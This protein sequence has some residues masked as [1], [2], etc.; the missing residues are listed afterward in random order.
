MKKTKILVVTH[1]D[2]DD[3]YISKCR[4]YQ[5]IKVGN[6]IDNEF[7]L[8]KGWLIDN[9]GDNISNE[10][11][12]Y[13]ELTAQYGAWK[14][15][16][17]DVKYIGIV[18]YRRYFFEYHKKSENYFRDIISEKEIQN[19]LDKYKIIVPFYNVKY[20]KCSYLYKNKPE[21]EQD[22]NWV[23]IKRIIDSSY[24]E[25]SKIFEQAMEGK[26]SVR[27][28]MFITTRDIYDEYSKWLFD[29]LLKYDNILKQENKE[30]TARVDGFLSEHLLYVWIKYKF[31][32]KE[33]LQLESRNTEQDKF[34]DYNNGV[35]GK[36]TKIM[37]CNR[38]M[39]EFLKKLRLSLLMCLRGR[40]N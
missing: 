27:G 26:I 14:N 22:Y 20:P 23:V 15:L 2:F 12:F 13:C 34:I 3:S 19:Y 11:P 25:M 30:R 31:N 33:V 21:N 38:K 24:P 29:V 8:K 36:M 4:E 5:I 9:V 32:N 17:K 37:K 1:K 6:N 10:N 39:L 18:H 16:D 7:A 28:N 40:K 35:I